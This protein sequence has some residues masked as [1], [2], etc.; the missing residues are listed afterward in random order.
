MTN[1]TFAQYASSTAFCIQ[2]SKNQ[3]NALLRCESIDVKNHSAFI[4]VS[5]GTLKPLE[6]RGLVYWN[7]DESGRA[8]GFAGLTEAGKLMVG[9]LKQA[10]LT[11]ENT[12]TVS[13][14]AR[15]QREAEWTIT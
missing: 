9:L 13:M 2:L 15:I 8:N 14:L 3:C 6:A 12:N 5:I 4:M 10:G 11:I 1:E 7:R